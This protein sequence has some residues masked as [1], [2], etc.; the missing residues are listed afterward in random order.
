MPAGIYKSICKIPPHFLNNGWFNVSL[1]LFGRSFS[2]A[3]MTHEI[4]KLE[5][6]DGSFV[7]KDYFGGYD[8]VVRP[9]FEWK[10]EAITRIEHDK[11]QVV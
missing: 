1:N 2:D 3:K 5:I 6:L 11:S 4:L 7:R 8:G 10:T 9:L